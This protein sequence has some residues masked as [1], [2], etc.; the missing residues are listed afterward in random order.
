MA[1]IAS[2]HSKRDRALVLHPVIE[3]VR[4]SYLGRGGRYVFIASNPSGGGGASMRRVAVAPSPGCKALRSKRRGWRSAAGA[5][6]LTLSST[7]SRPDA[8][9]HSPRR[10]RM[11]TDPAIASGSSGV[12]TLPLTPTRLYCSTAVYRN[13]R[14][15]GAWLPRD[16]PSPV[17]I[18][19][20]DRSSGLL[21]QAREASR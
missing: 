19:Q 3:R 17:A 7:T 5:L 10:R 8:S 14:S 21:G 9:N 11:G 12:T 4:G 2:A 13:P 6:F 1:A 18:N 16:P 20:T 15:G